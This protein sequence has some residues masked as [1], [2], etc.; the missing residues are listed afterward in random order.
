MEQQIIKWAVDN[1]GML[2]A[3]FV[4]LE[5]IVKLSPTQADDI[6]LDIIIKPVLDFLKPAKK[7]IFLVLVFGL[8]YGV[9]LYAA[10]KSV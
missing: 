1:W 7:L 4:I 9:F 2:L 10:Q 8:A 5:K 6:L 3:G